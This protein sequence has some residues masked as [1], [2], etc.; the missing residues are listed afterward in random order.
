MPGNDRRN[1]WTSLR[2]DPE[3]FDRGAR[4]LPRRIRHSNGASTTAV[5]LKASSRRLLPQV[6]RVHLENVRMDS[7]PTLVVE[8][9]NEA[10]FRGQAMRLFEALK[11]PKDFMMFTEEEGAGEHCQ[12]GAGIYAGARIFDWLAK[13]LGNSD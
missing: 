9:E 3:G 8:S 5:Y 12:V 1:C 7:C 10:F 2:D 11:C 4:G 6:F 13:T